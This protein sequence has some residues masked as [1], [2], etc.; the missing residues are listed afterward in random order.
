MATQFP[1]HPKSMSCT[2]SHKDKCVCQVSRALVRNWGS[3]SICNIFA[4]FSAINMP[5]PWQRNFP[6]IPKVCLAHLPTKTN[7]CAKFREHWSKTEE[8]VRSA[9]FFPDFCN[10]YAVTMATQFS[11]HPKSTSCITSHQ[12]QCVCQVSWAS[13]KNWG[14]S[15]IHKVFAWFSAINMPLPWQRSF[16]HIPKVRLA[17]LPTK[18]NVCAKFREHWSKTEEVVPSTR[19]LPDFLQ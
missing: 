8:V 3:S 14:R 15:S 19:F 1:I 17:H 11:T 9:R 13:A 5:L 12:D 4:W 2:S 10:K 6:H 18:T 7:V 16:P